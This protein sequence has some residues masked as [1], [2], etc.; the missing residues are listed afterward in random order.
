MEDQIT[1]RWFA[2]GEYSVRSAYRIQF[3]GRYK[4]MTFTPIWGARA[5]PKGKTFA[6]ILLQQKILTANNLA[7]RGW[8]HDPICKLCNGAPKTPTHLCRTCPYTTTVW[9]QLIRWTGLQGLPPIQGQSSIYRWWKQCRRRVDQTHKAVFDGLIIHFWWIIWK[10]RNRRTFQ[11]VSK[12]PLDIAYI[13][14]EEVQIYQEAGARETY[15]TWVVSVSFWV[16][17]CFSVFYIASCCSGGLPCFML[18]L[19][20]GSFF[21]FWSCRLRLFFL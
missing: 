8:P 19:F 2:N 10:E 16:G 17:C 13:I 21:L 1:W 3:T 20:L 9:D 4:K 12:L 6:W 5:E 15:N 7:K 18:R 11:Q 14:K